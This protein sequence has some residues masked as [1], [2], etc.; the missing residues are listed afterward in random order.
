MCAH[1]K[2]TMMITATVI[3]ATGESRNIKIKNGMAKKSKHIRVS[4]DSSVDHF[5]SLN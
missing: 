4:C 5:N 3:E 2:K 1:T